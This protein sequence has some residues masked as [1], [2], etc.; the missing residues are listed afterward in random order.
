MREG[1]ALIA[2]TGRGRELA[3]R[4]STALGGSLQREKIP[5]TVWTEENFGEREA[6]VFVG[7]VGIAVRTIA[8]HIRNKAQ[9]PAV[10]CVDETGRWA[11]PILSGHLGGANSLARKIAGI[12]G[13][14]AVITTATDLNGVFAVD[15]WAKRQGL[16]VLQPDRIRSV[17]AKLLSGE[18]ITVECAWPVAGNAP[19]QVRE[20]PDGDVLVSCRNT[21]T[22][23]LQ[24][25]P[26]ILSLGIGCRRGTDAETLKTAFV[27]FCAERHIL[28]QAVEKAA[29]IE[30]KRD[31]EGLLAFCAEAGWPLHFYSA[32]ELR[33][34]EGSFSASAFVES[35]VGVDNVC[36]R[37]AVLC[38]GGELSENK[39]AA[40]GVTFAL[41][42]RPICLDW[43]T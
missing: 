12:T 31:E 2:F 20:A 6:L 10:V 37:A 7:A 34:V 5:A 8:P 14:E 21:G 4:L 17:S 39:F 28:P 25:V 26:R 29:T 42:E 19:E 36:E 24:L 13:G 38:S 43:S 22:P 11:I 1:I 27:R 41:A 9:D 33:R 16:S 30:L 40:E 3:E 15:L 23:A 32:E 35:R 18:E